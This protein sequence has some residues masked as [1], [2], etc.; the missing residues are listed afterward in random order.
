VNDY[1]KISSKGVK[2]SEN[3]QVIPVFHG[4]VVAD[5]LESFFQK[6]DTFRA[7]EGF[8]RLAHRTWKLLWDYLGE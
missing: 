4:R 1:E 6:M 7:A 8:S 2:G 3:R 5:I